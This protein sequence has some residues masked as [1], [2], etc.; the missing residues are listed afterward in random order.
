MIKFDGPKFVEWLEAEHVDLRHGNDLT[1]WD[2]K[3]ILAARRGN[4]L[5]IYQADTICT[6]ANLHIQ[7]VPDNVRCG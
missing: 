5:S 6:H 1:D 4:T 7:L 2:L 3:K